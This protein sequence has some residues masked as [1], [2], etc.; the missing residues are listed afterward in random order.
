MSQVDP[1]VVQIPVDLVD[2]KTGRLTI[3][4]RNWFQYDNRWKH[5]LWQPL[6]QHWR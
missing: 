4:G 3:A 1:Y 2:P 6:Y 5:D